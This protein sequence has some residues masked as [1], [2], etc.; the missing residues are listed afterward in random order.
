MTQTIHH[1]L[2]LDTEGGSCDK[3]ITKTNGSW[4]NQ[5]ILADIVYHEAN[6]G[7]KVT[8]A[9]IEVQI[10]IEVPVLILH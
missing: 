6:R 4:S 2:H 10:T 1:I 5:E 9:R 8:G 3:S 7:A